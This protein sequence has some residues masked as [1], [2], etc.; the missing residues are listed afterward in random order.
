M[1]GADVRGVQAVLLVTGAAA[2]AQ[3]VERV[4]VSMMWALKV[5]RSMTAATRRASV[6]IWPHSLNGEVGRD[7]HGCSFVSFG[8]HLEQQLGAAAVELDVAELVDA[9]QVEAAP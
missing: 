4:P 1:T 5:S 3:T 2:G 7:G 6:M 8:E 9:Q